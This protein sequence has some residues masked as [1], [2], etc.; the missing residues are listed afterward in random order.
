[1]N[2]LQ[3]GSLD[4]DHSGATR[5][6]G[7]LRALCCSVP[8]AAWVTHCVTFSRAS[9]PGTICIENTVELVPWKITYYE[10]LSASNCFSKR[11]HI[12][13]WWTKW[14][15]PLGA[16]HCF[17]SIKSLVS[18]L[19]VF[20]L[21]CCVLIGG[22]VAGSLEASCQRPT[23]PLVSKVIAVPL[24]RYIYA[25]MNELATASYSVS[26]SLQD[27]KLYTDLCT[28]SSRA[29]CSGGRVLNTSHLTWRASKLDLNLKLCRDL[30][31]FVPS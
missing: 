29:S 17:T 7:K 8:Q 10:A 27:V 30:S 9:I 23:T 12:V 28:K 3:L 20:V 6:P 14:C 13:V 11:A 15:H 31:V 24:T 16:T 22:G 25:P 1:M 4:Y 19:N 26:T 18:I 2:R 21:S 5:F